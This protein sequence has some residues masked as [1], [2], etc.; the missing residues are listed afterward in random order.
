MPKRPVL[1]LLFL[2]LSVSTLPAQPAPKDGANLPATDLKRVRV[3]DPASDFTLENVDGKQISLSDFRGKK[4]VVL[5][6]YRGRW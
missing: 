2:L 5:A 3:G 6:F 1:A 4:N